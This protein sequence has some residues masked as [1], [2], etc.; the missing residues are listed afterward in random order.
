MSR[1]EA[2][3][4]DVRLAHRVL[5]MS[6]AYLATLDIHGAH[7]PDLS[8]SRE[9]NRAIALRTHACHGELWM[10][11]ES[12]KSKTRR[13]RIARNFVTIRLAG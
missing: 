5:A 2:L 10:H 6:T 9:R 7:R 11:N 12:C 3:G 4:R 13:C 1:L 8:A